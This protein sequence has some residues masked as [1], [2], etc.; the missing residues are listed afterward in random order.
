MAYSKVSSSPHF[1]YRVQEIPN[2]NKMALTSDNIVASVDFVGHPMN[3][4]AV[5]FVDDIFLSFDAVI[6]AIVDIV[7]ANIRGHI[8][9]SRAILIHQ[10]LLV[11]LHRFFY[12]IRRGTIGIF[13]GNY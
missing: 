12:I 11:L 8:A 9:L 5:A 10:L 1:H 6:E 3:G 4:V 2:L 7:S 13:I